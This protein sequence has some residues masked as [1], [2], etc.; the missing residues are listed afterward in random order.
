MVAFVGADGQHPAQ[1]VRNIR[2]VGLNLIGSSMPAE[3]VYACVSNGIDDS[4]GNDEVPCSTT[5]GMP[6]TT[7]MFTEN[8]SDIEIINCTIR[9]AGIAAVWLQEASSGVTIEGIFIEDIGGFRVYA[10]GIAPNDTRYDSAAG[11]ST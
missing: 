3:Y 7:P 11:K 9:A 6:H 8:A 1:R 4:R 2:L 10:N 5:V